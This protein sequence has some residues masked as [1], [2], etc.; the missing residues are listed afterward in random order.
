VLIPFNEPAIGIGV[1]GAVAYFH[2]RHESDAGTDEKKRFEPP[3]TSFGGGIYS[4]NG[5]WAVAGGH[6][7]VWKGG[8][9]RYLGVLAYA[10]ANFDF[11]GIGND[12]DLSQNP[13]P[14]NIEGGG[15]VQE[16]QHRL[17]DSNFFAGGRYAFV[18]VD[19]TF[20]S[21]GEVRDD[22]GDSRNA[23]VTAF[24]NYDSRDTMFTPNRGTRGKFAL[25]YFAEAL[26]GDFDYARV[27]LAGYHYWP[28]KKRLV[29]GGRLEYQWADDGAPFYALPWVSLRGIP[30]FRYLGHYVVTG[31]IEPRWKIDGRW[32]VLAFAGAGRAASSLDSLDDA[33]RAYNYGTG[34]RYLLSRKLGMGAGFDVARGPEDTVVYIIFGSAWGT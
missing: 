1:V 7:G 26:G 5:T 20:R 16:A 4:D 11:Y 24:V 23:G 6:F 18:A 30:A 3:S 27:D 33:E 2:P 32:S 22:A 29:F 8:R 25:S 12:P 15:T 31:E 13:V 34:F 17:G 28:I 9:V 19:T 21:G 14:V 10:S